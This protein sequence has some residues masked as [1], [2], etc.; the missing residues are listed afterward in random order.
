MTHSTL[1]RTLF[2]TVAFATT[3]CAFALGAA[4]AYASDGD[5]VL[6]DQTE[7]T[8]TWHYTKTAVSQNPPVLGAETQTQLRVVR[9]DEALPDV[10]VPL[11][12][13]FTPQTDKAVRVQQERYAFETDMRR[14]DLVEDS[15]VF[16]GAQGQ[17]EFDTI[18]ARRDSAAIPG[19]M[20]VDPLVAVAGAGLAT[21]F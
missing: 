2:K 10:V 11:D 14:F 17:S 9:V 15:P 21:N 1:P 18:E 13:D 4:Q 12:V 3:A 5:H 7:Q 16:I 8:R 6:V 19:S 20:T